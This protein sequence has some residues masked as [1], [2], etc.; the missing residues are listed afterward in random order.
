MKLAFSTNAFTRVSVEEAVT[1]IAGLG[2]AGVEI[3]ADVPHAFPQEMTREDVQRL[4]GVIA[5]HAIPVSNVNAFMLY[6]LRDCYNPSFVD[7]DATARRQRIEHTRKSMM[8]ARA[9]GAPSVSIEPGGPLPDGVTRERAEDWFAEAVD[10][11]GGLG[12]RLH[13][14]VLVEPEPGLLIETSSQFQEFMTRIRSK[15]VGL[16]FDVGHF[17]SAGEDPVPLVEKLADFTRHY[18]MEDIAASR[19]HVHLVPGRGAIPMRDVLAAIG[20]TG[21]DGFVTV[22]LYPYSDD[23]EGAAKEALHYLKRVMPNAAPPVPA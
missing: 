5:G 18:H 20:D 14:D 21:F 1:T 13:V 8:L 10:E 3:M 22:E 19:E 16:N 6:G 2:Y 15:R 9:I 11:L 7:P 23:P 17:Y 4:R 12:E